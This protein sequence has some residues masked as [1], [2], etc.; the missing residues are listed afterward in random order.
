MSTHAPEAPEREAA[1]GR[2]RQTWLIVLVA[3]LVIAA[4]ALGTWAIIA[5]NQTDDLATATEIADEWNAAW[6]ASDAEAIAALFTEDG[7]WKDPARTVV[8]RDSIEA[9]AGTMSP[10]L[11]FAERLGDGATTET[12]TFIFPGRFEWE[13]EMF[14]SD[15]EIE[16][17][18]DLASRIE[19]SNWFAEE[20]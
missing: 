7:I 16:L 17:D 9:T 20:Q 8:G 5:A 18:G 2:K 15:L 10:D 1:T 14:L 6:V 11:T 13:G 4:I 19:M 12:G 3:V